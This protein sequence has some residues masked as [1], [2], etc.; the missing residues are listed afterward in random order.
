MAK[1]IKKKFFEIDAP[2][3]NDKMESLAGSI[4]ELH[5][6]T[7]KMDLTRHL[8]GKS[9]DLVMS[10]AVKDGKAEASPKK[11]TLLPSFIK[12]ML[13]AGI[14]YVEDSFP[15]ETKESKVVIKPFLVTRKKVSR[16]VRRTLRN[17]AKNWIIDYLKT[18]TDF[19]IFHDILSGQMQKPL[20]LRL[21]KIYPL[22]I[23]EIR[24]FELKN[25]LGVKKEEK[26]IGEIEFKS[27]SNP[28]TNEVKQELTE[29]IEITEE[30]PKKKSSK[31]KEVK[32]EEAKG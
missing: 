31:K 24:I 9:V 14:D 15:A 22:A 16:A 20:S 18:K 28:E 19:E 17:S 5:N 8:K 6:K 12:H 25:S 29:N 26:V 1:E 13:H 32:A 3:L 4:E 27:E 23:C 11:L 7:L 30:K 10:I 2:L 21:K